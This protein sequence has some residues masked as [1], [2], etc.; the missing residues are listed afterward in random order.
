MLSSDFFR[1]LY[2]DHPAFQPLIREITSSPGHLRLEGLKGS[3]SVLLAADVVRETGTTHLFILPEAEDAAY[4][5]NDLETLLP[6]D[7]VVYFPSIYKRSIRYGQ[8]DP[9]RK[10][11]RNE[12]L[13]KITGHK[14]GICLVTWPEALAEK[15]A[16][17]QVLLKN[18]IRLKTG[19]EVPFTGLEQKLIDSGFQY[20][21]IIS[22]PGQ[23]ALR[24]GIMDVFSWAA[25][26]P[27][28][29]E[30]FGDTIESIRL[31][32]IETQLSVEKIREITLLP[33]MRSRIE[34]R[35][36]KPLFNLLPAHTRIWVNNYNW[37]EQQITEIAQAGTPEPEPLNEEQE[38]PVPLMQ[39]VEVYAAMEKFGWI[40]LSP[41]NT[42]H[43]GKTFQFHTTAQ[44]AFG[45]NFDLFA[46]NLE[47]QQSEGYQ[48]VILSAGK[49]Q[50]ERIRAILAEINPDLQV[51]I[52]PQILHE[53]FTDHDLSV[54]VY[55]D[56]QLFERYHKYRI[57]GNF[58]RKESLSIE[59]LKGLR[60]GDY[61][62]HVDH[63][64]GQ[65]GGLE[66]ISNN[67]RLQEAVKLVYKDQDI[68]YVSIH[69]LHR[70]S[71]YKGKDNAPPRIY[72]LGSRAWQ[73]L[74]Q[75]TKNR[76][77]DIARE[78]IA[79]YAKR[80]QQQGYAFTA[81]SYLQ[82]ELE[83]SFMYEDTPDQEAAT[84][85]V[86]EGMESPWPM[87]MLVCGD[88][89]FGKT[90]VAIRASFKAVADSKQVAVLV[91]TTILALQHYQTFSERLK[92]FPCTVEYLSRLRKPAEQK[93]V[94]RKIAAGSADIV[95]GTHRLISRDIRFKDLGLLI[96]D[97][98][99]KFGVAVKEK[100]KQLRTEVDTLTLTA[101]PIPRT[102][103][104][105]LMGA[106]DFS[107]INTPPPN[108]H[109][110]ITELHVFN[111]AIIREGIE[112]EL[113]RGGQVFFI[114]NRIE[115]IAEVE[116]LVRTAVPHARI[117]VVHGRMKG[118]ELES[119]M[120]DFIRGNYDVLIATT[121]IESGLDIP[122]ANTI[123][124]NH[125]QNFG[126]SDL[127]Q[128]RGRVGRSNKKAFCYLLAPPLTSLTPEARRRLK[129]IAEFSELGS[130][131]NI[132]LQDLDIRGAG[133]LLGAEQS[134]FISDIGFET[135]QRILQEAMQELRESEFG[136]ALS[137][138]GGRES[139]TAAG[140]A[141]TKVPA[142]PGTEQHTTRPGTPA[143]SYPARSRF[144]AEC[145]IDTD[146][147]IL[148]PD[149][150]VPN[151]TE[152]MKLYRELDHITEES[153]LST[154]TEHLKDRFGNPPPRA[155]ALIDI[156][157]IRMHALTLGM[158]KIILKQGRMMA[159]FVR[160]KSSRFY[161]S[162]VFQNLL[163]YIQRQPLQVT[164]KES[165]EKLL[166]TVPAV[167]NSRYALNI[168]K[169]L[170]TAC[171]PDGITA[172]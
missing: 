102:L 158:E 53:G 107:I 79:L 33:D 67:G 35:Q 20:T 104:F 10:I 27:C 129:A 22:Q 114:H 146:L 103:Q 128:L 51:S 133:N 50:R 60:P 74:K 94:I 109:P 131:F 66:Q 78:L 85:S 97:E 166:L 170:E 55:T 34:R 124:I 116:K 132:A 119:V 168:L 36:F 38:K 152:K 9:S 88:V 75:K 164:L 6:E 91:P 98:E 57:G 99:Q 155:E 110:I 19:E 2:R 96:I 127:H 8:V 71:K 61:V 70:I 134:G 83:A 30:F 143:R 84:R 169:K 90:E 112:Y 149:D 159:Y 93:K 41:L 4:F 130:G 121:I 54:A 63:G 14:K 25:E 137:L 89:G 117:I 77:K 31:F 16:G 7:S 154:F 105:S 136:E 21:D 73:N 95:I 46:S 15:V 52:I 172:T 47:E 87:D 125:A 43:A 56:H 111:P 59:E 40:E 39:P 17:K 100:L 86:K 165:N 45:K 29:I 28:R 120:L 11:L 69:A 32:D 140:S 80:I 156:V 81:D 118:A 101:T 58:T 157:R 148:F 115:N 64:I 153:E 145:Q 26:Q 160:D 113:N 162:E 72:K 23:Y 126:L 108:R 5:F 65:F 135:Y 150:Y 37:L 44:P 49:S 147:E 171:Y 1:G 42:F 138:P 24:G 142:T 62:I 12:A 92:D 3:S 106:R 161:A 76:V 122:N 13:R 144:V 18:S 48:T 141:T 68:L 123:F 163:G 151:V 139:E 82:Q 167:H